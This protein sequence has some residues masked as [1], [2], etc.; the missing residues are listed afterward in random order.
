MKLNFKRIVLIDD[1]PIHNLVCIKTIRNYV[2]DAE[3]EISAFL[4]PIEALQFL[5]DSH[6]DGSVKTMILIDINM[7]I[8]NG[9]DVLDFIAKFDKNVKKNYIIYMLSSSENIE[10]IARAYSYPIVQDYLVKPL[11][12]HM[13]AI[14]V[15]QSKHEIAKVR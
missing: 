8:V 9:W 1:D 7:N 2:N 13:P 6:T 5:A 10:D 14:F 3:L 11:F 15:D 12:K 4:D